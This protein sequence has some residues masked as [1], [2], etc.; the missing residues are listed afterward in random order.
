MPDDPGRCGDC[1][2]YGPGFGICMKMTDSGMPLK[3]AAVRAE[4]K[5]PRCPLTAPFDEVECDV[6]GRTFRSFRHSPKTTCPMCMGRK[7]A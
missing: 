1:P 6:C 7:R 3:G 2:H 4:G 5:D